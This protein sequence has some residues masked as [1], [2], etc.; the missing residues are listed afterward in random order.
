MQKPF[1]ELTNLRLGMFD[2]ESW[3]I[4][5]DSFLGGTAPRLRSL[6]LFDVPFP[7]LPKLLMSSTHLVKLDFGFIP[8]SGYFPPEAMATS[9]SALTSLQSLSLQFRYPRPRPALKSGRLPPPTMS[10]SIL[11]N[12]TEISFKGVSEYLE[13][14][15]ARIDAPRLNKLRITFFH[16][17]IFDTPRLFQF[18]SQRPTLKALEKGHITFRSEAISVRFSPE[19][20]DYRVLGLSVQIPCT[21]SDWQL[22][23][24]GQVCTSS[25]PPVSTLEDLHIIEERYWPPRWKDDVENTLWLDLLRSFVAVKD[26]YLSDE[27]VPCIAP[28]LQE[29]VGGRTTEVLSTAPCPFAV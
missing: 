13:E 2:D 9:L 3:P 4:V 23:S 7:G 10:R 27:I 5:P 16:Q 6:S 11:P 24:L 8:R 19:T 12:L 1:P 25:L 29:L 17:M 20:P 26:L 15:L 28:A 18:I 22:S 14:I 21:A